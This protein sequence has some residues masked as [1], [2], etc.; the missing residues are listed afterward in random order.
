M[1]PMATAALIDRD[2][3]S[4]LQDTVKISSDF[5]VQ[6]FFS[7]HENCYLLHLYLTNQSLD[8][9]EELKEAFCIFHFDVRFTKYISSTI[10]F[11]YID[12]VR[13]RRRR[14]ERNLVIFD[15]ELHDD[16]ERTFGDLYATQLYYLD[17]LISSNPREMLDSIANEHVYNAFS[18][19]SP[20]QKQI[21]MLTYSMCYLDKEIAQSMSISPQ[22]VSKARKSALVKMRKRLTCSQNKKRREAK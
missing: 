1:S 22:A 16:D 15:M 18:E 2:D 7:Y 9:W 12:Y 21:L 10:R 13:K 20:K 8:N 3:S 5:I 11:V 19:L 6:R 14:E 4:S 17:D